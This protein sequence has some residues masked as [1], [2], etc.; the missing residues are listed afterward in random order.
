V[1]DIDSKLWHGA[2][3]CLV[4]IFNCMALPCIA[5]AGLLKA[6]GLIALAGLLASELAVA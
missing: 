3:L 1:S 4:K 6:E 5:M 2:P